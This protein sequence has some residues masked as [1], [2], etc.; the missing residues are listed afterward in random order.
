MYS[1]GGEESEGLEVLK[2]APFLQVIL[3]ITYHI[4]GGEEVFF[5]LRNESIH[6]N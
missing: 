6:G 4:A 1:M 3:T 5:Y 2:S